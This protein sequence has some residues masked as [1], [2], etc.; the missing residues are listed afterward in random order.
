M[1][2]YPIRIFWSK[3]PGR[4]I[5]TE[6]L[7]AVSWGAAFQHK[8]GL[9]AA[10]AS[11]PYD[12]SPW[13]TFQDPQCHFWNSTG[14]QHGFSLRKLNPGRAERSFL[15]VHYSMDPKTLYKMN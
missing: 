10:T 1:E 4:W 3:A 7:N 11:G 12:S 14:T 2:S 13:L 9:T 15:N 5:W 8:N 6:L